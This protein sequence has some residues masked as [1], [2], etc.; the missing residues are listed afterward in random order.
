LDDLK[1]LNQIAP[2]F[3]GS[4]SVISTKPRLHTIYVI[5]VQ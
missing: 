2:R 5:F 3:K 1:E 4:H